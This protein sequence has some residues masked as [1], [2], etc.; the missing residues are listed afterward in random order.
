[1]LNL[2]AYRNIMNQSHSIQ[3]I[4]AANIKKLRVKN[5]LTQKN[6]ARRARIHWTYVTKIETGKKLPSLKII[7][8]LAD[9]LDVKV[10]ELLIPEE[11]HGKLGQKKEQLIQII[12]ESSEKE[13]GIYLVIIEALEKSQS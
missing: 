10:H 11:T 8:A 5:G 4:I 2:S 9:S 12:E 13:L 1:M 6:L 7:C 3:K